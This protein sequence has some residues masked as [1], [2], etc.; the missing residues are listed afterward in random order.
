MENLQKL[1]K[2]EEFLLKQNNTKNLYLKKK[3]LILQ[4]SNL[5]FSKKLKSIFPPNI[6][7]NILVS[8]PITDYV[9]LTN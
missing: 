5:N 4:K 9:N 3:S 8:D 6:R 7:S 1:K 2:K